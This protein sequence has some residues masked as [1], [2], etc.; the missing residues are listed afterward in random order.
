MT[1][2]QHYREAE[3]LLEETGQEFEAEGIEHLEL[4]M[5]Q[6]MALYARAQ[7]HATLALAEAVIAGATTRPQDRDEWDRATG[8]LT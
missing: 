5:R 8:R 3:R 2:P 7:V 4:I 1:G 6:G